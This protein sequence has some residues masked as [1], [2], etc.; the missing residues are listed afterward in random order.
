MRERFVL[1]PKVVTLCQDDRRAIA[2]LPRSVGSRRCQTVTLAPATPALTSYLLGSG[3][4]A[5]VA[6]PWLSLVLRVVPLIRG[7]RPS[8]IHLVIREL[9]VLIATD[10]SLVSPSVDAFALSHRCLRVV[11]AVECGGAYG[12]LR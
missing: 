10:V 6:L 12:R 4:V 1:A 3:P 11:R 7:S 8:D 9:P 2:P 5:P